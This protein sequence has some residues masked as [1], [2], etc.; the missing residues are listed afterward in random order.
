MIM[1]SPVNVRTKRK[2]GQGSLMDEAATSAAMLDEATRTIH[3]LS[4]EVTFL[5]DQLDQQQQLNA[6]SSSQN[7]A[8]DAS[9]LSRSL[10]QKARLLQKA[11]TQI[12]H[13][14]EENRLLTN[15]LSSMSE[16]LER[17]K[18]TEMTLA[19]RGDKLEQ[20]LRAA[21]GKYEAMAAAAADAL[22]GLIGVRTSGAM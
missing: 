2:G 19:A 11:Q 5:R 15:R 22:E 18:R 20:Q 6:G 8:G 16:E 10:A 12:D 14:N 21:K 9:V 7:P 17:C 1:S 4:E 13:L 3:M